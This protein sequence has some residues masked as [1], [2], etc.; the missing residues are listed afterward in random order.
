[1]SHECFRTGSVGSFRFLKGRI[2]RLNVCS[3]N[4]LMCYSNHPRSASIFSSRIF[5]N[6]CPC[7]GYQRSRNALLV[8]HTL[9]LSG[10]NS[11]TRTLVTRSVQALKWLSLYSRIEFCHGTPLEWLERGA[12]HT[13]CASYSTSVVVITSVQATS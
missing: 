7:R 10:H 8:A 12:I 1:M 5:F 9:H 6:R 4:I 3:V 11:K 13:C 2:Y